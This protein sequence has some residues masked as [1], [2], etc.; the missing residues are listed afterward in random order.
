MINW[1]V[2]TEDYEIIVKIVDRVKALTHA[3]E[4]LSYPAIDC[5]MDLIA[6]HMNG[7]PLKLEEMLAMPEGDFVHDV[8]GILKHINRQTGQ[9]ENCFVPRCYNSK[10]AA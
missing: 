2:K 7:M 9:I 8:W 10:A 3:R 1:K 5:E 4:Y 6:C